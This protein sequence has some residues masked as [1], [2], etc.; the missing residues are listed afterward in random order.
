MQKGGVRVLPVVG[1]DGR[2]CGVVRMEDF[3]R[4]FVEGL[5]LD[6]LDHVSLDLDNVVRALDGKVLVAAAP[7]RRLRDR[8]MVGA[9]EIDSMVKR[10]EPDIL[11]VMGDRADAQRAAIE[12]GVGALVVTGD[13]PVSAEIIALARRRQVT[14]IAVAHHTF[15]T[16]RLIHMSTPVRHIMGAD[17][18]LCRP[19]DIVEDVR[20]TLRSG[21]AR[22]LVV[23]DEDRRVLGIISRT[24]L[25]K[26][27][28]RQVVLVDHNERGQSVAGIEEAE[29]IGV[30][31]HHR[32]AD[33]QTRTP[34]FMRLEPVGSTSTIVAKLFAEAGVAVPPPIAGVLLSGILADTLVFRGPTTTAEDRRIAA[35]LASLTGVDAQ[36][37]GSRLLSLASDVSDRTALQILMADFKEFS[38]DDHRFGIGVLETTNGADVLARRDEL[39]REMVL[40]R[41]GSR[42]GRPQDGSAQAPN[43]SEGSGA[44]GY[45][46]VLFAV[47][48]I[49]AETTTLLA[50]GHAETVAA[51]FDV[52][53][54]PDGAL[55]L[56][57]I[58]S[59]KKHI[60]PLLGALSRAIH[61]KAAHR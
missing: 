36:E 32:V 19:D 43:G 14:V 45:T 48:D 44:S 17:V 4:V 41:Q 59:R 28:R 61:G 34:P 24:N 42:A 3:A 47:I 51:I 53:P 10:L 27:V 13:H 21:A 56:P 57:G 16:V 12:A 35:G 49:V 55:V 31:D 18:P 46:S 33:F 39:L 52:A 7:G 8:V 37:L 9:M 30:V 1:D 22:S 15:T 40:L 25:L 58:L 5:D 20:E 60:V 23:V 38:V 54:A 2:L 50:A 11:V 6:R 26:P 29:V